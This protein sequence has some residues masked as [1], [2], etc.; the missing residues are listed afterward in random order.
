[1]EYASK[2]LKDLLVLCKE[3]GIRGCS[4]KKR[5]A[6]IKALNGETTFTKSRGGGCLASGLAF[7]SAILE[8]LKGLHYKGEQIVVKKTS[9]AA[10]TPDI[11]ILI[12]NGEE[13]M[14]LCI[15][16]KNKGAFEA[17]G[18]AF[19]LVGDQLILPDKEEFRLHRELL[20]VDYKPF[21]GRIPSFKK[22]D[23]KVE[24]WIAEKH[25]F[26][27]ERIA[28]E[29]TQIVA[30]YYR[31]QGSAYIV[32]EEYG[33]YH[34]GEDILNLKVPMFECKVSLRVRC[35]Q[36]GS[37]PLPGSVQVSINYDKKTLKKS[38]FDLMD[39][40]RLPVAMTVALPLV[41]IKEEAQE[42]VEVEETDEMEKLLNDIIDLT[43]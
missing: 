21:E 18:K 26:P 35:K 11:P 14:S 27:E 12:K 37:S 10:R 4:G 31:K 33:I 39:D 19:Q 38:P 1:M 32:V 2:T 29:D 24:T 41:V 22:G 30:N 20:G 9:G 42:V 16:V 23:K 6:L 3:K 8:R 25:L 36:H 34:T 40:K 13:A 43:L 15:E 5:S 28:C 7:E 17:G